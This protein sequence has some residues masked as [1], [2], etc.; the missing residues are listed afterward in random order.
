MI[1][2]P[3]MSTTI[4]R[5]IGIRDLGKV[6]ECGGARIHNTKRSAAVRCWGTKKKPD[7]RYAEARLDSVDVLFTKL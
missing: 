2:I 3:R 6:V 1:V 5:N 4:T 7:L